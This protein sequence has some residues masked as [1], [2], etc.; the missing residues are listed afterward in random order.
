[1][2]LAFH[3]DVAGALITL[4]N[5]KKIRARCLIG[6]DGANSRVARALSVPKPNYAGYT[7]YR[8]VLCT[9]QMQHLASSAVQIDI[10]SK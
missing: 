9:I 7:A 4:E 6:A 10:A 1:M 2:W 5:G 8:C 3:N